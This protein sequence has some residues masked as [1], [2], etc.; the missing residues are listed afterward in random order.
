MLGPLK[1]GVVSIRTLTT[2]TFSTLALSLSFGM[3]DE[4][5]LATY[6]PWP[7]DLDNPSAVQVAKQ[8]R[9][10][11]N[12][13]ADPTNCIDSTYAE[14]GKTRTQEQCKYREANG[15]EI[16][17]AEALENLIS[18]LDVPS[19]ILENQRHWRDYVES[20]CKLIP[21]IY[22]DRQLFRLEF[23][24]CQQI[25]LAERAIFLRGVKVDVFE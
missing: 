12:D 20:F 15:W 5:S 13:A 1:I 16:I 25:Q 21:D 17:G 14:C 2:I 19:H 22:D 18:E 11:M 23:A 3:A 10:C 9:T 6:S 8:L 4:D 7:Y 24:T